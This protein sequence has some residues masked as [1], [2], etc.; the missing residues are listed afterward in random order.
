MHIQGKSRRID[1]YY[2]FAV[3][4]FSEAFKVSKFKENATVFFVCEWESI[5]TIEANTARDCPQ[6]Y[7]SILEQTC[8]HQKIWNCIS[9]NNN[10][11]VTDL[12]ILNKMGETIFIFVSRMSIL[13]S[14]PRVADQWPCSGNSLI[15]AFLPTQTKIVLFVWWLFIC[16]FR[17]FLLL[18][19]NNKVGLSD[20]S[21]RSPL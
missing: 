2:V 4:T 8:I 9:E 20:M 19:A 1:W 10:F 6:I 11:S 14:P 18:S 12:A 7:R 17:D 13:L 15:G 21:F 16:N 3:K 5:V